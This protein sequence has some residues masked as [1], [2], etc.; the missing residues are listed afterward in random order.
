MIKDFNM[1]DLKFNSDGLICAIAQDVYNGDVLMQ[2]YMNKQS[3]QLSLDTG[4][5]TYYSRSRKKLWK[6][7]EESGHTQEIISAS[8]DCDADCLLFKVIQTGVACHTGS[9]NCFFNEFYNK[10]CVGSSSILFEIFDVII[11]RKAC[12]KEGSYTN[13][14]FNKGT[15]KIC[16][17]LGEEATECVIAAKNNDKDELKNELADLMYHALV[18][19]ADK[20]LKPAD[21][22]KVLEEREGKAPEAKYKKR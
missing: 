5:M 3:L 22:F 11:D 9:A 1:D 21:V 15:D 13:Y 18:L 17:K 14:L 2:A 12:P 7:G 10:G 20:G 19:M 16:K 6:K 8:Y 4:F